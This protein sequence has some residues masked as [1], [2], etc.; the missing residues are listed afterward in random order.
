MAHWKQ[1]QHALFFSS[2]ECIEKYNGLG[3]VFTCK[4]LLLYI[5]FNTESKTHPLSHWF[6]MSER[7][8]VEGWGLQ[9]PA[10]CTDPLRCLS[11]SQRVNC[12]LP[13]PSLPRP[14]FQISPLKR[15]LHLCSFEFCGSLSHG[16]DD[17]FL[18]LFSSPD[19]RAVGRSLALLFPGWNSV[20]QQEKG[21]ADS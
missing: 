10:P 19:H 16:R 3:R 21:R 7:P 17:F 4:I 15:L 14:A 11:C 18:Y 13:P 9:L 20:E 8:T 1:R 2:K 5:M 12:L 6:R